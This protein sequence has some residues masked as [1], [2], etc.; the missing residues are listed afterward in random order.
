MR[1]V[2]E[3][4]DVVVLRPGPS[5][6]RRRGLPRDP[7]GAVVRVVGGLAER[8]GVVVHSSPTER[9]V[10]IGAGRV[11]RIEPGRI[12]PTDPV[13]PEHDALVADARVHASLSAGDPVVYQQP[14][15]TYADGVLVEKLR[16]GSLIGTADAKVVAV[17]FRRIAPRQADPPS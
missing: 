13:D 8:V 16:F 12:V 5:R 7:V 9:D 10:W 15:G 2:A 11:Q 6:R 17:G 1:A 14:D 4:H 3:A